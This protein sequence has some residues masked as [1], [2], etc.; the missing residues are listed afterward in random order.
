MVTA[1]DPETGTV[2][3]VEGTNAFGTWCEADEA[4]RFLRLEVTPID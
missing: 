4:N 2:R 1:R 3:R